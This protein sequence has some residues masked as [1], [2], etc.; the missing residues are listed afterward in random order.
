MGAPL[1]MSAGFGNTI[2]G[3]L[4]ISGVVFLARLRN[5]LIKHSLLCSALYLVM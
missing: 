5:K 3:C 4:D 1:A 2:F